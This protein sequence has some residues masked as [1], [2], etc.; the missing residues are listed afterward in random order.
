MQLVSL[1]HSDGWRK[2]NIN[3]KEGKKKASSRQ[4]ER[5]KGVGGRDKEERK[6]S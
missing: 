6:E 5:G 3:D 1:K 2:G 4:Q